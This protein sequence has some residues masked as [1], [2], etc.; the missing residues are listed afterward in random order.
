MRVDRIPILA[1]LA[2]ALTVSSCAG[3]RQL[4]MTSS[5]DIPAA[6]SSVKVGTTDNGNTSIDLEVEHMASP[7]RVDPGATVY[8]V[9]V[10]GNE[11]DAL[12]QNMGALRVDDHLKGSL[13]AVT[14][15][16]AFELY[17]TAESSQATTTPA[18]KTLLRTT[19]A[20]K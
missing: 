8:I 12:P 6:A 15:L 10:R 1:L 13:S 11:V 5:A 2:A 7:D 20:M 4:Q 14:P 9:W 3:A 17:V 16:R 18:G 19:V